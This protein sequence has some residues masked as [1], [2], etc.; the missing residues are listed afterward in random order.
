[1]SASPLIATVNADIALEDA[2]PPIGKATSAISNAF[3]G[4][5]DL[6][7]ASQNVRL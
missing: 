4:K 1:M 7:I 6:E 3:G 5:A 2:C